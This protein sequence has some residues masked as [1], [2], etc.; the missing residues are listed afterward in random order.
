[1]FEMLDE[2]SETSVAFWEPGSGTKLPGTLRYVPGEGIRLRC[3]DIHANHVEMLQGA[4]STYPIFHGKMRDGPLFTLLDCHS[5]GLIGV[6]NGITDREFRA[7]T[8]LKG[9][10]LDEPGELAFDE[11]EVRFTD[12]DDWIGRSTITAAHETPQKSRVGAR[13]TISAERIMPIGFSSL[14]GAP[15]LLSG[16]WVHAPIGQ[17][18]GSGEVRSWMSL[19][20]RPR[21]RMSVAEAQA[22]AFRVQGLLS[23]LCGRQVFQRSL[24]LRYADLSEKERSQHPI[25]CSA[26]VAVAPPNHKPLP[27]G[28]LLPEPLV[29][30][31]L[32]LIWDRWHT[33]FEDYRTTI[34]LFMATE[35]FHGQLLDFQF[36][37]AIQAIETFHRNRFA[38]LYMAVDAFEGVGAVLRNA[39][40]PTVSPDH[41]RSLENRILYGNE[42]SLRKRLTEVWRS[43]PVPVQAAI[44][45]C[46][47]PFLEKVVVTR[48]YLTHFDS[49]Q[50]TAAFERGELFA[51][52]QVLRWLV[53][54][55]MLAD[56][57]VGSESLAPAL[58]RNQDLA[59]W[60]RSLL[61]EPGTKGGRLV[62]D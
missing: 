17:L 47:K 16:Q 50:A 36:L 14:G 18:K 43:L 3:I 51:A 25:F 11:F 30:N 32:P 62:W 22:A 9:I 34:Q 7:Q 6:F 40:P 60:R 58:L 39:I 41:R 21:S 59:H 38:G 42:Y 44:H 5:L 46:A 45:P 20:V 52:T 33:R 55:A 54:S 56:V 10:W 19:G 1:M 2:V 61:D 27:L 13:Y 37:S 31:E 28:V 12:L 23:L 26:P 57:G 29:R 35:L 49:S 15:T 4:R 8:L 53:L 48:N 24:V